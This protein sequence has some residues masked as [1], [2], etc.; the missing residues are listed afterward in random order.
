MPLLTNKFAKIAAA[1]DKVFFDSTEG[2][3]KGFGLRVTRNGA[4]TWVFGYRVKGTGRQRRMVIGDVGA[5]P[6]GEARKRAAELR[7]EV[8]M[9]GDPQGARARLQAE[10]S[11]GEVWDRYAAEALPNLA[12]TT[13][14]EYRAMW[15]DHIAPVLGKKKVTE[16]TRTDVERLHRQITATGRTRRANSV[17][18][19]VST[20]F[21][22]AMTWEMRS[23]NPA[24]GVKRN[25]EHQRERFLSVEEVG[26]LLAE[27]EKRRVFGGHWRDSCDKIELALLTGARRGEVL[28]MQWPHIENLDA[29]ATWV[30]P[31]TV[32]KEG[33]RTGR[34]KR[35]PLSAGAIA[36]LK[37]RRDEREATAV[38]HLHDDAVFRGGN[39]KAGANELEADWF[40]LR[41]AARLDDVRFHDLRHS[42]ASFAIAE[43]LSLHIVGKLLGHSRA[44]TTDRYA[45]LSDQ[46]MRAATELVDRKVRR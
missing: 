35:L 16:V 31:S 9:G 34:T 39:T 42:F 22:Q 13:Q 37:R 38:V 26:R 1:A 21:R 4:K 5:W 2:S 40:V 11:V 3:P 20:V 36:V 24:V 10:P 12:S 41:A 46:S 29:A 19:L 14:G 44:T 43:G 33:K 45:H 23:D 28:G 6:V 8:D 27:I 18:S 32:T 25:V 30:L 17:R 15:R 7:R